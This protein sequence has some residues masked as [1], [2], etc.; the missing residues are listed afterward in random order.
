MVTSRVWSFCYHRHRH[1]NRIFLFF[2]KETSAAA[3]WR[4]SRASTLSESQWSESPCGSC[5]QELHKKI[6]G[7][8]MNKDIS[9]M[10]PLL[11]CQ[12]VLPAESAS[13]PIRRFQIKRGRTYNINSNTT[14]V[15]HI[16]KNIGFRCLLGARRARDWRIEEELKQKGQKEFCHP[17]GQTLQLPIDFSGKLPVGRKFFLP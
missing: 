2:F 17:G 14:G 4:G 6:C 11:F 12:S 13:G 1:Q 7:A 3:T 10:P 9:G 15:D 5:F 16:L 8:Y